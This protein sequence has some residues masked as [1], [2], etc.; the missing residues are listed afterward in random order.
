VRRSQSMGAMDDRDTA[1][2]IV[3]V[4]SG[5]VRNALGQALPA[6]S[7]NAPLDLHGGLRP[8]GYES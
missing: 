6:L 7:R 4:G 8:N 1:G 3:R 5:F 2:F